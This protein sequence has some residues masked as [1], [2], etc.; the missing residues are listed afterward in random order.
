MHR[1]EIDKPQRDRCYT[2]QGTG[3][4]P[5]GNAMFDPDILSRAVMDDE[6]AEKFRRESKQVIL[7]DPIT[8]ARVVCY[9]HPDGRVLVDAIRLPNA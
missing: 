9:R 1:P 8:E 3:E 4:K 6:T 7:R 2:C 5:D